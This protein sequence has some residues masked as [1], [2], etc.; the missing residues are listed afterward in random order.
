MQISEKDEMSFQSISDVDY[1]SGDLQFEKHIKGILLVGGNK[2][3][4][5]FLF[6]VK[7]QNNSV[8]FNG[9]LIF[10][11]GDVLNND[12]INLLVKGKQ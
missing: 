8:S 3:K 4:S 6:N 5:E 10:N 1:Y 2:F 11:G 9:M 12:I 7:K